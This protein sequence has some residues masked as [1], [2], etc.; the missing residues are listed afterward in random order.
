MEINPLLN[1]YKMIRRLGIVRHKNRQ[2]FLCDMIEG[3]I[4]QRAVIFSEIAQG[5]DHPVET[6]SIERRIQNFFQKVSIEY[7]QLVY[8]FLSFIHHDGLVLSI[9]RTEWDFG[10]T[11]IN[12]LCVVVSIGKMAVP[13]YFEMLDNNSGNSH[14]TDRI[15][16]FQHLIKLIG[17]ARISVVIMDREFIG[18]PWLSWLKKQEI[19]FCVRVPKHHKITLTDGTRLLAEEFLEDQ[20]FLCREDLIVD[21]VL[22]NLSL[23]Y[24]KDAELLYLIGTLP[25]KELKKTYRQRWS[26]E[27]FFQALKKRGFKLEDSCLKSIHKYKKLFA[28]ASMAYTLC[29]ATGIES[30][31]RKPVRPKNHGYP[32]YSVF[33]RGLNLLRTFFKK[34]I[35]PIFS[36]IF[37]DA[38]RRLP[39]ILK[40]LG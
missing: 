9:D 35:C 25:A 27:V 22:V 15:S 14:H 16:L 2:E 30:G 1:L 31:R 8:F 7:S 23:S 34:R 21:Q 6:A 33:R 19:P 29:W 26:I 24:T 10:K 39:G 20:R 28:I 12:I 13:L 36:Q 3:I 40:T 11:Q 5:I 32:Q 18:H 37:V 17:K 4:R 38:D